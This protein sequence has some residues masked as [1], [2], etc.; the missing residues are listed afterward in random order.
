MDEENNEDGKVAL[1]PT[2]AAE[3]ISL[4]RSKMYD[5]IAKGVIPSIRIGKSVRVPADALREWVKAQACNPN[6][7]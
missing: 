4:G 2:E 6:S 7:D 5:L 1:R 3:V